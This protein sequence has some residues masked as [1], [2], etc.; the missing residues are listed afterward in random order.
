MKVILK[1]VKE[2]HPIEGYLEELIKPIKKSTIVDGY[3]L[4]PIKI[5]EHNLILDGHHRFEIAKRLKLQKIPTVVFNYDDI[6]M[7]SLRKDIKIKDNKE[8]I[9]RVLSGYIYPNKTVKHKFPNVNYRC[10]INL[11]ELL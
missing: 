8:V 4:Y 11:K 6:P 10:K 9:E 2:L 5:E 7:W 3:W 1:E